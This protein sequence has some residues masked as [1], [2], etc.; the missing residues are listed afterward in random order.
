MKSK[1][2]NTQDTMSQDKVKTASPTDFSNLKVDIFE[3]FDELAS[4]QQ[5]W[6][7][8]VESV[9]SEIFLT[10]DWC[11]IWWKHYGKNRDLKVFVFRSDSQLTGIIPLFFEKIWLGPVPIRAVKIVGTDFTIN[12][13]S[14]PIRPAAF[15]AVVQELL[16]RLCSDY[17][18]DIAHIGPLSGIYRSAEITGAFGQFLPPSF[19]I[20]ERSNG[21]QAYLW[22]ADTWEEHL[23]SLSKNMQR[24]IKRS[25]RDISQ[26]PSDKSLLL[27]DFATP[28][29]CEQIF[30]SFVQLHQQHWQKLRKLGHFADWPAAE[31]F[32]REMA[33]TQAKHNRLRLLELKFGDY[34]LGYEYDYKFANR[35]HAFLNARTPLD[36][37]PGADPGISLGIVIFSEQLKR[38]IEEK[39]DYIDLMPGNDDYKL[40]LGG[41]LLPT[42][43]IYIFPKKLSAFIRVSIFRALAFLLD[44]CYYRIWFLKIAPRLPFKRRP[45]WKTW[46]KTQ[47]FS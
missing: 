14:P 32:H 30:D 3:S 7:N 34:I 41:K 6:D 35:R 4:M 12:T 18:W 10:Y 28:D 16:T 37:I 31:Q 19:C 15:E 21:F 26:I 13:V 42:R 36:K 17:K 29:N 27:A 9:G 8:F 11:R 45:L 5:E 47:A 20:R 33:M 22:L 24:T 46:I 39:A 2:T 38:T 1:L 25:Y 43:S 23:K 44:L 40:H